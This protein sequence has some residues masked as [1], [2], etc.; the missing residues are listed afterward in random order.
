[1]NHLQSNIITIIFK[2]SEF[3]TYFFLGKKTNNYLK[4]NS[5]FDLVKSQV[6]HFCGNN[7][8]IIKLTQLKVKKS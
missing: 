3:Y 2:N 4:I 7:I 1:M 5:V 6:E 8:Y